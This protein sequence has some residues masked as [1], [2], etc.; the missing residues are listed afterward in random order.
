MV[1]EGFSSRGRLA[2]GH[3]RVDC[4]HGTIFFV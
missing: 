1:D 2:G 3:G 4:S